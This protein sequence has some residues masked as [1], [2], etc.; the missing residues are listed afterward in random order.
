[1]A[2]LSG[3]SRSVDGLS[4]D[5]VLTFTAPAAIRANDALLFAQAR[6]WTLTGRGRDATALLAT[7]RHSRPDPGKPT[8]GWVQLLEQQ[9]SA[10]LAAGDSVAAQATA[11]EL[12]TL[13]EQNDAS[14]GRPYRVAAEMAALAAARLGDRPAAAQA[15]AR[16]D[17]IKPAFPSQVDAADSSIRRREVLA[18][19]GRAAEA[20]EERRAALGNLVGQ[21]PQSPRLAQVR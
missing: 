10:E 1:M 16:S 12:M 6:L 2:W 9:A 20:V 4:A 14:A 5:E 21:S 11:Q 13:L 3:E 8:L 7:L 19:L 17:A 18:T 15:L